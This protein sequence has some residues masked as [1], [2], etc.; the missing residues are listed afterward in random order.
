[1]KFYLYSF[2]TALWPS[3]YV[4]YKNPN[5]HVSAFHVINIERDHV[6]INTIIFRR[7]AGNTVERKMNGYINVFLLFFF[8]LYLYALCVTV[9]LAKTYTNHFLTVALN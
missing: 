4:L 1:M 9:A 5:L 6:L 3:I 2:T 7:R 8:H